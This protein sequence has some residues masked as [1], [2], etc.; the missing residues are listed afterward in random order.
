MQQLGVM[1]SVFASSAVDC[2]FDPDLVKQKTKKMVLVDSP[3]N[4]QH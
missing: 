2:G 4:M 1:A 3:L